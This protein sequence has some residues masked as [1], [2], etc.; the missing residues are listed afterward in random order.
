MGFIRE[1]RWWNIQRTGFN[2]N[3]FKNVAFTTIPTELVA[4]W[5]LDENNDGTITVFKDMAQGGT[6]TYDPTPTAVTVSQIML[7]REINIILC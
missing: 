3:A 2:I 4:Y 7:M 5:R 1:F 6:I